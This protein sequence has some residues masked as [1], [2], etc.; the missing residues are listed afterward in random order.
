MDPRFRKKT[1]LRRTMKEGVHPCRIDH[2]YCTREEATVPCCRAA[3]AE[4]EMVEA[5][6]FLSARGLW[7]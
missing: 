3:A 7:I 6:L 5:V 2:P 4:Q 1:S